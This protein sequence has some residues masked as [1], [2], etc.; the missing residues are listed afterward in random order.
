T[1]L[2]KYP[3]GMLVRRSDVNK[4]RKIT[5][6]TIL[7][8]GQSTCKEWD[9]GSRAETVRRSLVD[10]GLSRCNEQQASQLTQPSEVW[11]AVVIKVLLHSLKVGQAVADDRAALLIKSLF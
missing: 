8:K 1:L 3:V 4:G 11:T 10:L 6:V 2:R 9:P 5:A 7:S